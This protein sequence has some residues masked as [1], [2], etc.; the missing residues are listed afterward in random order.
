MRDFV[1]LVG[2]IATLAVC[3]MGQ[4][5]GEAARLAIRKVIEEQQAAWNR[6]DLEGFMA[7]YWKSAE[8]TFFS[9]AHESTGWQAAVDR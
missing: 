4:D 7:G 1:L 6:Q 9:G 5:P 8:L 3:S 2:V